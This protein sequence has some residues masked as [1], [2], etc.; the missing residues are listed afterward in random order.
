MLLYLQIW[1]WWPE[2]VDE[3]LGSMY[4]SVRKEL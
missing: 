2:G 4:K 1:I 3:E